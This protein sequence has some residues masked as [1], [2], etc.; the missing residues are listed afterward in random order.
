MDYRGSI[1][2]DV[3]L[4]GDTFSVEINKGKSNEKK[5]LDI[6]GGFGIWSIAQ[7]AQYT[8]DDVEDIDNETFKKAEI[9]LK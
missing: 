2:Y 9:L 5:L 1:D 7:I 8:D 4:K 6:A 3:D